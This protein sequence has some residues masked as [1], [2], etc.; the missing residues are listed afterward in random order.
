MGQTGRVIAET[1]L[2][3][4][5]ELGG[6]SNVGVKIVAAERT[7]EVAGDALR[8]LRRGREQGGGAAKAAQRIV[9]GVGP[10]ALAVAVTWQLTK[11]SKRS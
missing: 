1:A 11:G 2:I 6:H 8:T 5:T 10:G 3:V 9:T 4:G 7:A